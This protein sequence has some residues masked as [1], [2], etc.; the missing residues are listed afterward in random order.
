M[1]RFV[2]I[3]SAALFED[4]E[5]PLVRQAAAEGWRLSAALGVWRLF[6]PVGA[7]PPMRRLG[8]DQGLVIGDCFQRGA[9]AQEAGGSLARLTGFSPLESARVLMRSYWGRYVALLGAG[10]M[11]QAAVFRDPSGAVECVTARGGDLIAAAS[12]IPDWLLSAL[13]RPLSLDWDQIGAIFQAPDQLVHGLA[14]KGLASVPPGALRQGEVLAPLWR[15]ADHA[16]RPLPETEDAA[17]QLVAQVQESVA[18]FATG[19][20]PILA[21]VSGG[22]DSAIIAQALR[23]ADAPVRAWLNYYVDDPWGDE[24]PYARGVADHAGFALTEAP[25]PGGRV[26]ASDFA[27]GPHGVRP[28]LFALDPAYDQDLVARALAVGA[29]AIVT[30][31]GGDAIFFQQSTQ[32]IAA[33]AWRTRR[34]RAALSPLPLDLARWT[35][36]PVWSVLKTMIRGQDHTTSPATPTTCA[37]AHPW[38][39]GLED[40]PPAKQLHVR[41]LLNGQIYYGASRRT[42]MLDVRHPLLS[43]PMMELALRIPADRL[44]AGVRDRALARQAFAGRVPALVLERPT[45]GDLT[46]VYGRMVA[47]SLDELRPWLLDGRLAA[48]GILD[49]GQ[50]NALLVPETLIRT[51]GYSDILFAAALEGWVRHWEARLA[52]RAVGAGL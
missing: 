16:L 33:D 46:A 14:L 8:R 37:S 52:R 5:P 26:R 36:T 42:C 22:L 44:T 24:R 43:Q 13:P 19:P 6:A 18:A 2:A 30:G 17:A 20:Q 40:L 15:P 28:S 48:Q 45:K 25:K 9:P 29:D 12:E 31:Q 50:M 23:R 27:A 7:E 32:L 35:R 10:Q 34:W 51:G 38:L 1:G 4:G 39:E 47:N 41:T 3:A 21:E 49:R 11:S